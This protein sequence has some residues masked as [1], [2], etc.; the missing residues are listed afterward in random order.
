MRLNGRV[1]GVTTS[2]NWISVCLT[3]YWDV[4]NDI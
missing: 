1:T 2:S 4:S 3:P